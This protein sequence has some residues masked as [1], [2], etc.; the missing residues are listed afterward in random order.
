MICLYY[1][2]TQVWGGFNGQ[3]HLINQCYWFLIHHTCYHIYNIQT[4]T[5]GFT[6]VS[7]LNMLCCSLLK[8]EVVG[9]KVFT[10]KK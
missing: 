3:T 4:N 5:Q 8:P 9:L 6:F 7:I 10:L 2:V 1:V